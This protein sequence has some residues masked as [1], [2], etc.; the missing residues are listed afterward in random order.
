MTYKLLELRLVLNPDHWLLALVANL[1]RPVLRIALDLGIVVLAA[2]EALG[3]E[4]SLGQGSAE[5]S[6]GGILG[7]V[8]KQFN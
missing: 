7:P 8:G 6:L 5:G 2:N 3:V 1:K 4:D